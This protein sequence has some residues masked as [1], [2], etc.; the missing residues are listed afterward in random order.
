EMM[1]TRQGDSRLMK[2]DGQRN[3]RIQY[4]PQRTERALDLWPLKAKF[5][6]CYVN[7]L[8]KHLDADYAAIAEQLFSYRATRIRRRESVDQN[9]GV[10][11]R[12][13]VHSLRRDRT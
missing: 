10:E 4:C 2:I 3:W 13:S 9:V 6:P 7:E 8:V 12:L 5:A 11:K 1:F